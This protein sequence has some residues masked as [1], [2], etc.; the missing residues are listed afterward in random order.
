MGL[1][2]Q[3]GVS[4]GHVVWGHAG[5]QGV[6]AWRA[7]ECVGLRVKGARYVWIG[8]PMFRERKPQAWRRLSMARGHRR[9]SRTELW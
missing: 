8:E 5:H 4:K 2:R 7:V 1:E 6:G 3:Q 9:R